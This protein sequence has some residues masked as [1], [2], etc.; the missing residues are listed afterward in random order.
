MY[1]V[2]LLPDAEESFKKLD[3][4]VQLRIAKK[5]DWLA[6]NAE[7]VI[8]HPLVSLPDDL[9]GLCRMRVGNYRI[10]YWIYFENRQI[11]IYDIEH[12]GKDYRSIIKK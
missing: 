8:H 6:K 4:P 5:I 10:L 7:T 12:R 11:K 1:K 3:K 9:K 2:T